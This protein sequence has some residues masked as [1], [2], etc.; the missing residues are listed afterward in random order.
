LG[1]ILLDQNLGQTAPELDHCG[2]C[3][4]C[5]DICPTN[6]FV[7]PYRMD[8]RLCLSY[9][10]IEFKGPWPE[11]LR[12]KMGNRVYGCD[13]CLAVCPW[14][15]YAKA[16]S[17]AKLMARDG[18]DRLTLT[19]LARLDDAGFR[20]LFVKSPIKRIGVVSFLR[21]VAYA[22]GNSW[23]LKADETT[24]AAIVHL[25]GHQDAVVRDAATWAMAQRRHA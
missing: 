23:H 20:A 2:T 22:L 25:C 12:A 3:R 10:S 14:N 4:A 6:A 13:D 15:K 1:V 8:A 19:Q 24:R 11:A 7:A 18:F 5:L 16:G 9:L 21:N 17:E